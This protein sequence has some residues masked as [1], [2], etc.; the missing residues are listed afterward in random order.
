LKEY[1]NEKEVRVYADLKA[2]EEERK[3]MAEAGMDSI[4]F[5]CLY[6]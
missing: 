3:A 6:P 5:L 2:Q 1:A 4:F